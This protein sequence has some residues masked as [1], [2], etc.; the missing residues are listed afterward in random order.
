MLCNNKDI[1]FIKIFHKI[2]C[3]GEVLELVRE[4]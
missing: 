4:C 2:E 1:N 3:L